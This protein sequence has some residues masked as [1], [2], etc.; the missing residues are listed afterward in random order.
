MGKHYS[1]SKSFRKRELD[2]SAQMT[3]TMDQ[4][5]LPGCQANRLD[6]AWNQIYLQRFGNLP[7]TEVPDRRAL[8]SITIA[9]PQSRAQQF[10]LSSPQ[11][12]NSTMSSSMPSPLPGVPQL[13]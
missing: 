12:M 2:A 4:D 7:G 8:Q 10:Q 9:T 3:A 11:S 5:R 1:P 13:K 6:M